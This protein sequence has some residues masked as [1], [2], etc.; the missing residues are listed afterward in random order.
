MNADFDMGVAP[1]LT[2]QLGGVAFLVGVVAPEPVV[3]VREEGL[4]C[5]GVEPYAV[6]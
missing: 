2:V 4:L 5:A 3:H 6:G 1:H